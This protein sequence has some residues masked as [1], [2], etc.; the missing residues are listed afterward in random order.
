M[1]KYLFKTFYKDENEIVHRIRGNGLLLKDK[2]LIMEGRKT[3]LEPFPTNFKFESLLVERVSDN[4]D[5][6]ETD[7]LLDVFM[8]SWKCPLAFPL[9]VI[10]PKFKDIL[11]TLNSHHNTFFQ[12]VLHLLRGKIEDHSILHIRE[13]PFLDYIDFS[14]TVVQNGVVNSPFLLK[15]AVEKIP[16]N[17]GS[18]KGLQK[19]AREEN[20]DSFDIVE[21]AAKDSFWE[22]DFMFIANHG[23]IVSERFVKKLEAENISGYVAT[24]VDVNFNIISLTNKL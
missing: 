8:W 21:L 5:D 10:S 16:Q 19:I 3:G 13:L 23:F 22:D 11:V 4:P 1:K 14:K 24:E 18:F 2:N 20:W 12:T 9:L 7:L 15:P 17:V 6:I